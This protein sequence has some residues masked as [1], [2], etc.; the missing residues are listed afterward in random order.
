MDLCNTSIVYLASRTEF[1]DLFVFNL[2]D[3][4][5]KN[6]L[7][8]KKSLPN[9]ICF[10]QTYI[11]NTLK[12]KYCCAAVAILNVLGQYDRFD[13]KNDAVVGNYYSCIWSLGGVKKLNVSYV[14]NQQKMGWIVRDMSRWYGDKEIQYRE[15]KNPKLSF[16]K[17]AIDK[18]YASILGV[19]TKDSGT[20]TGHAV[21]VIGY[22]E[23]SNGECYLEVASG[24]GN[25]YL[26][27]YILYDEINAI[28][29]YGV[30]FL[31]K[32]K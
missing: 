21:S 27:G 7:I 25:K 2:D 5:E 18:K 4:F 15:E 32:C 29:T 6:N 12:D 17:E 11:E 13:V 10:G 31:Q 24:W 8:K 9:Q 30:M 22:L 19:T 1:D 26:K 20:I 14:M 28:S 16:F 3:V 23:F